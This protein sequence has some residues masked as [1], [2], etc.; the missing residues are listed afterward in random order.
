MKLH[1]IELVIVEHE[2]YD[3]NDFIVDI[4]QSCH[5]LVRCTSSKS[6]EVHDEYWDD[7]NI[8]NSNNASPD[9]INAE[10]ERVYNGQY[11]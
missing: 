10:F 9:Q 11:Q 7:S 1:K 5:E 2:G 6:I 3:V 8:I 4:T